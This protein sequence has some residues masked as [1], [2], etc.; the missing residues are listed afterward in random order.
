MCR[1]FAPIGAHSP[2]TA[3]PF[4]TSNDLTG[5]VALPMF[6]AAYPPTVMV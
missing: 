6:P 2:V 4:A 5:G 1:V 3:V